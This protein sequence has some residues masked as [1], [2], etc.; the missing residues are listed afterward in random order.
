MNKIRVGLNGFGRIG[1]AFTRIAT[2]RNSFDIV[3]INTGKTPPDMLSYLLKYDS[4]YRTFE[5][6]VKAMDDGIM[7]DSKKIKSYNV[8][9][10]KEIA[11]NNHEVD[12]VV[13]CTGVFKTR[14]DLSKHLNG[15]VKK[16]VLTAPT[17]DDSIPMVVLGV[18]DGELDFG[19]INII[20]NASCTT[21]CAAP[22]F[23]TL[24][25]SLGIV[26]GF[27]TTTHAYTSSQQLLDNT[28]KT[29]AMSRA[30]ALSIIPSTTGAAKAV[31]KIIPG[32]A[33]K[34]DGMAMRV[35]TPTGSFT[36]ISCV[37]EKQTTADEINAIF[38]K[39]SEGDMKNVLSYATDILVSSD[40][41]GSP[42][43]SIFDSNYTKVINGNLVKIF[44]WYDNEWGYSTRLVDL[45]EKLSTHV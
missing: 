18:N 22:L 4:V 6:D 34:V 2:L 42:F 38:K 29:H 24:H 21:N 13:D 41:I 17:K 7:I 12:V 14:E 45:V 30:A 8:R 33:G 32:L 23:K 39:Q 3:A 35:P 19:K 37:V 44:S 36:D 28:G 25:D 40:Y 27:L 16:V 31:A 15:T 5:K 26:S 9:D 11:W 10:P 20:S 1:R 43:S